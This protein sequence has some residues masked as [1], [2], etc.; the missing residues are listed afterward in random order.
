MVSGV[1]QHKS[2][3]YGKYTYPVWSEVLGL[4]I[5]LV[6]VIWIPVGAIHE[7]CSTKG[8]FLQVRTR[9]RCDGRTLYFSVRWEPNLASAN[10]RKLFGF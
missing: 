2:T 1:A 3:R 8:S 6:S 10:L 4:G 7:L 9:L 5:A